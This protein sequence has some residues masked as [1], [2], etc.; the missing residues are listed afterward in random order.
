[1]SFEHKVA[2][3]TGAGSGIGRATAE[4]LAQ[5]GAAVVVGDVN[6]STAESTRDQ[7][8]AAGGRAT[9]VTADVRSLADLQQLAEVAQSTFGGLDVWVNS[10][11]IAVPGSARD[12]NEDDWR[13]VID[14]NLGGVWRGTKVALQ[15]MRGRGGAIVN[16][17]SVQ[18]LVGFTGWAGYAAS[19]GGI[20]SFT[21]QVAVEYASEGIRINAVAPGTI[22]TSMT[23]GVF[24]AAEDPQA[25]INAWNRQHALG[26][27][28]QA[29][30]VAAAICY[31]AGDDSSFITGV[32]LPVDAG[33]TVMGPS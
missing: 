28:G 7:I 23:Q 15:A 21:R 1:M 27:F 11:G 33:M 29:H 20:N 14:V 3:V 30:E 25:L 24:D 4:R 31:L 16:V 5:D 18:S 2:V 26:R 19:K 6:P 8:A 22:L 13:R 32:C 12:M 17:S 9:A 10:A